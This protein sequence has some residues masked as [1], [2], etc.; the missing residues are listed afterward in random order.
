MRRHHH[1]VLTIGIILV[2]V[3]TSIAA[4]GAR[5]LRQSSRSF[6]T[7]FFDIRVLDQLQA[8]ATVANEKATATALSK[9]YQLQRQGTQQAARWIW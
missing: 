7:G 4:V 5:P 1:L 3:G 6:G 9:Q 8:Q 2:L